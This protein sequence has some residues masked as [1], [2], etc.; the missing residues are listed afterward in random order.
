MV[1]AVPTRH[2]VASS[3]GRVRVCHQL[4]R[5]ESPDS[6]LYL[7]A[8]A[9]SDVGGD[10]VTVRRDPQQRWAVDAAPETLAWLTERAQR[11]R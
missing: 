8:A 4:H 3:A 6:Q 7:L 1:I 10:F 2:S 5:E 11:A 9:Y